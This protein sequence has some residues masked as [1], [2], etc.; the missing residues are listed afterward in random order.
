MHVTL[1]SIRVKKAH[2]T[3]I[4]QAITDNNNYTPSVHAQEEY[5]QCLHGNRLVLF[6]PVGTI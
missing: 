6:W 4:R 3:A 1:T 5:I 2:K